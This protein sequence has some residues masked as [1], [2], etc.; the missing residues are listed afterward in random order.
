MIAVAIPG[1]RNVMQKEADK[2]LN[3]KSLCIEIQ[4]IWNMKCMIILGIIGATRM[5]NKMFKKKFGSHNRK[6]FHTFTTK[7]SYTLEHHTQYGRCCS[8]KLEACA[9]RSPLAQE[10]YKAERAC[11]KR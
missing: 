9:V 3:Y 10:K 6:T 5:V 2:K 8:L 7:G 11:D 4:Q 1:G